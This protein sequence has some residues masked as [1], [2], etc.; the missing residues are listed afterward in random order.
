MAGQRG[1]EQV[2]GVKV[3]GVVS[4]F[5]HFSRQFLNRLRLDHRV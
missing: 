1:R 5:V 4:L 2:A 3:A